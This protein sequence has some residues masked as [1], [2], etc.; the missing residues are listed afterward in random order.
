MSRFCPTCKDSIVDRTP[1]LIGETQCT[2]NCPQEITCLDIQ[3]SSCVF[4]SGSNLSCSGIN[5]G[6][7]LSLAI[8]KINDVL[9][10]TGGCK[11]KVSSTDNCCEYLES[12]IAEGVGVSIT[13]ETANPSGCE[14]L[15]ISTN[16]GSL[17]WNNITLPASLSTI[18]GNQPPQYSNKDSLGRVW[19]RGSFTFTTPLLVGGLINLSTQLPA[20]SR[21]LYKRL[22]YNGRSDG[23][24]TTS[25]EFAVLANG[26]MYVKNT[27]NATANIRGVVSIDGFFIDTN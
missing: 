5:Y 17:I 7:T 12:K 23:N 8:S 21:P 22:L 25:V 13:K 18:S 3:P 19:F 9:C 4:Y 16:P 26:V 27:S 14:R 10:E 11:V 1:S 2:S 6:D 24:G 15:L 20:N